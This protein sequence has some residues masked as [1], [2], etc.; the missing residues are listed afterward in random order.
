[1]SHL[2]SETPRTDELIDPWRMDGRD[3][4]Y[5][6]LARHAGQLERELEAM[7]NDRDTLAE[8]LAAGQRP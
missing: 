4:Q 7:T 1:M 8:L 6:K 5:A 3:E 2:H